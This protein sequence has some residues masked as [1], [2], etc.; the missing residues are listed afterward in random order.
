MRAKYRRASTYGIRRFGDEGD[1]RAGG[2]DIRVALGQPR[3]LQDAFAL[4]VVLPRGV[5]LLTQPRRALDRRDGA[6][7]NAQLR[8]SPPLR[9]SSTIRSGRFDLI[10]DVL[11]CLVVGETLSRRINA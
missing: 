5:E 3:Q 4:R 10:V 1:V 9:E 2:H 7:S 11:R 6:R 8:L